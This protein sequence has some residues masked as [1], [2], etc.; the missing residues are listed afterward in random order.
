MSEFWDYLHKQASWMIF[1]NSAKRWVRSWTLALLLERLPRPVGS[2][3]VGGWPHLLLQDTQGSKVKKEP[4]KAKSVFL[5][6]G[7]NSRKS[8]MIR[9]KGKRKE[10]VYSR[11]VCVCTKGCSTACKIPA[12]A[13]GTCVGLGSRHPWLCSDSSSV[14]R[15]S[16]L[17]TSLGC[18]EEYI[19]SYI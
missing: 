18:C 5:K 17:P 9:D 2:W 8:T 19:R 6:Q 10:D 7:C 13:T 16:N 4:H 11:S 12:Y 14:K 15:H 1:M 3:R